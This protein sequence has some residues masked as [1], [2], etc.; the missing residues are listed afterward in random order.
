MATRRQGCRLGCL[1]RMI[2]LAG[3]VAGLLAALLVLFFQWQSG[4]NG[5]FQLTG[6]NPNLSSLERV[7]LQT[8]LSSRTDQLNTPAGSLAAPASFTISP[9]ET[10]DQV[11]SRLAE[12]GAL[13][14]TELFLNYL[15]YYG[16]DDELE[17]G[18]FLLTPE[19]TIPELAAHLT[20]AVPDEVTVRFLEGWRAEEIVAYLRQTQP[21][22]IDADE[23]LAMVQRERPFPLENYDFL[24]SLPPHATLEGFLFPDTY[25]LPIDADAAFLL[26]LM[27]KNFGNRVTPAMRQAYGTHGLTLREAVTLASIVER[28]AVLPEERPIMA[29]VFLNRLLLG[30]KLEADPTVQYALGYQPTTDSWWKSPL[31]LDDLQLDSPYNTYLYPGLP[32]GPIA[33]PGLASL[34]AVAYPAETEFLFFVVDCMAAQPGTHVFSTTYEEHLANVQRCR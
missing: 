1:V 4:A 24:A 27:L 32:P 13:N 9:G 2:L 20:D 23:F 8:Y 3:G 29:G 34:Q 30:M 16:M 12:I 14:D 31:T 17:A 11:A 28:E 21:A 7:Y 15:R 18:N 5:R 26:D 25:R 33:N 22:R 6:G 19:L 10:A